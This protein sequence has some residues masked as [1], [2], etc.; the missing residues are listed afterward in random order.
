MSS[1]YKRVI[2]LGILLAWVSNFVAAFSTNLA[3]TA[4]FQGVLQGISFGIALPLFISL[5]S[6]WFL[7][8]RGLASGLAVSGSGI[9]GGILTIF[10]RLMLRSL[11]YKKT[12]IIYVRSSRC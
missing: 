4:V 5:P 3:M 9:G 12:L 1:G 10:L 7:K 2:A 11:G 8:R 6:H